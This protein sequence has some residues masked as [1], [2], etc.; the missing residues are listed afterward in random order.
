LN[1]E[2]AQVRRFIHDLRDIA[3]MEAAMSE[4]E[5]GAEER[6]DAI[7]LWRQLFPGQVNTQAMNAWV[8]GYLYRGATSTPTPA[9]INDNAGESAGDTPCDGSG[10][11]HESGYDPPRDCVGCVN[12]EPKP[13]P[14]K[15]CDCGSPWDEDGCCVTC[16]ADVPAAHEAEKPVK[17]DAEA[18]ETHAEVLSNEWF[19]RLAPQGSPEQRELREVAAAVLRLADDYLH[20]HG[21]TW[22]G[23]AFRTKATEIEKERSQE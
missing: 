17:P 20:R 18:R 23:E 2:A 4:Y 9:P 13:K 12:C 10:Y 22:I 7:R 14:A 15:P 5:K 11:D 8:D 1:R 21:V 3:R 16:G 6:A 19:A